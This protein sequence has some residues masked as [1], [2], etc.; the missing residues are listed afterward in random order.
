MASAG[1]KAMGRRGRQPD[2]VGELR[3]RQGRMLLQQA[4]QLV[5]NVV[6]CVLAA[7]RAGQPRRSAADLL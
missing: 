7:V 2:L 5:V 3:D 1:C 6:H 4:Q